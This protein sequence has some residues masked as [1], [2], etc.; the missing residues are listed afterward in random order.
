MAK[1][2]KQVPALAA[3]VDFWWQ[4]IHEDL[5]RCGWNGASIAIFSGGCSQISLKRFY[6]ISKP[7]ISLGDEKN[8]MGH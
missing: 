2:R 7:C 6:P 5:S 3:L 8:T 1:F 4:G